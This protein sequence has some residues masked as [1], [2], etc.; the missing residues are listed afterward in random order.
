V[1]LDECCISHPRLYRGSGQRYGSV[2]ISGRTPGLPMVWKVR[3]D[4]SPNSWRSGAV[5]FGNLGVQCRR[6]KVKFMWLQRTQA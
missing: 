1:Q 5:V 6:V 2:P 3:G 4:P